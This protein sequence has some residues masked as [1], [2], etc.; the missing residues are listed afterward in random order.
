MH[1]FIYWK[2]ITYWSQFASSAKLSNLELGKTFIKLMENGL[3]LE[4][5]TM[6]CRFWFGGT[7]GFI[8]SKM[9]P[10]MWL[11]SV[12]TVWVPFGTNLKIWTSMNCGSNKTVPQVTPTENYCLKLK[13]YPIKQKS[14]AVLLNE[15]WRFIRQF[16]PTICED[17][18]EH[19]MC[20]VFNHV[21]FYVMIFFFIW[22]SIWDML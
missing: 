14:I 19:F 20:F 10:A 1:S 2:V 17:M 6:F 11:Q 3:I 5:V 22:G 9:I 13:E 21:V 7:I 15:M 4:R 8:F 12:V 16:D 18:I